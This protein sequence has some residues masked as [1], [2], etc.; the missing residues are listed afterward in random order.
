MFWGVLSGPK[1]SAKVVAPISA[2]SSMS[3]GPAGRTL[4][5]AGSDTGRGLV[6][7]APG[8]G[9]L[10]QAPA[11]GRPGALDELEALRYWLASLQAIDKPALGLAQGI[12]GSPPHERQP[13]QQVAVE[14]GRITRFELEVKLK[15]AAGVA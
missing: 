2:I 5:L 9:G 12:T 15:P 11:P 6:A 14:H 4:M 7:V 8:V 3:A 1:V 13:A 10:G